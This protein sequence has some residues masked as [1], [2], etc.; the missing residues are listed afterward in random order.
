MATLCDLK[1]LMYQRRSGIV[2]ET[3]LLQTNLN[4]TLAR[5]QIPSSLDPDSHVLTVAL[6]T[7]VKDSENKCLPFARNL[8]RISCTRY[9][10]GKTRTCTKKEK[11]KILTLKNA[12]S[13]SINEHLSTEKKDFSSWKQSA[14]PH[15]WSTVTT[16]SELKGCKRERVRNYHFCNC[17][18]SLHYGR[19]LHQQGL[20]GGPYKNQLN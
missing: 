19:K 13:P 20:M 17:F 2:W 1:R 18:D 6:I 7:S 14:F 4:V 9:H 15:R 12:K 11:K 10:T 3:C 8:K 16:R 5:A